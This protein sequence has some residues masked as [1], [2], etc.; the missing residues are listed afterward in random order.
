[1]TPASQLADATRLTSEELAHVAAFKDTGSLVCIAC[2]A[3]RLT[4][5]NQMHGEELAFILASEGI[6]VETTRELNGI[7]EPHIQLFTDHD[8]KTV[9]LGATIYD[10][11]GQ[12]V[13]IKCPTDADHKDRLCR[14]YFPED[15]T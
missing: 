4:E 8:G 6:K 14:K 9:I 5:R 11:T 7:W 1:M 2:V 13:T 15:Y 10:G 12:M 3:D